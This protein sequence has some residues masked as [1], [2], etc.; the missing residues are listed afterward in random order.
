MWFGSTKDITCLCC[1]NDVF[2][3]IC[4]TIAQVLG[5]PVMGDDPIRLWLFVVQLVK[6]VRIEMFH[7]RVHPSLQHAI[8]I[9]RI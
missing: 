1:I 9:Q 2:F 6:I 5:E 8:I 7:M 3:H 4:L